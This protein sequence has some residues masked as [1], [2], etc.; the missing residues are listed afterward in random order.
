VSALPAI[1]LHL[2]S[3]AD[4]WLTEAIECDP[5]MMGEL[6]GPV[7]PEEAAEVHRRR[8]ATVADDPWWFTIVLERDEPAVGELGIWRSEHDG[9]QVDEI[10]WMVL[11]AF[12]GRGI[13]SAALRT[14]LERARQE[15][16]FERIH[17]FPGVSNA[18]SNALC[19]K[20]GFSLLGEREFEFRDRRLRCNH[21]ELE[22]R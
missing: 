21:W 11:P 18:P 20:L 17:A 10:G 2:Y 19:R 8:M 9:E 6:G 22:L 13:A 5:R 4:A 1:E 15:P 12:Q 3:D 7:T 16:R 14:L